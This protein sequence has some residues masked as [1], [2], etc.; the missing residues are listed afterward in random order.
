MHKTGSS[1]DEFFKLKDFDKL[2]NRFWF[3]LWIILL[4]VGL[5]IWQF[6]KISELEQKQSKIKTELFS[7]QNNI[8]E[9]KSNIDD[10]GSNGDELES[11]VQW[12][13]DDYDDM[14]SRVRD[15]EY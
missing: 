9:I 7:I 13:E 14:E 8:T 1:S 3:Q 10:L 4:V 5:V 15:L 11:R 2:E 6:F 12:L